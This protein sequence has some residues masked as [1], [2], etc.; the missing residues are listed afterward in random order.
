[1]KKSYYAVVGACM[2]FA[3]AGCR[4]GEESACR[5]P[6]PLVADGV[7]KCRV[8]VSEDA[9]S[10]EKFGAE[11]LAKYLDKA[12]GCGALNGAYPIRISVKSLPELE[13]DGFVLDVRADGMDIVGAN[14]RGALYGCYEVLKRYAGIR[15]LVPGD[16]GEYVPQAKT[17]TAPVGRLVRNPYLKIREARCD[18][19][20]PGRY[21]LVRNNMLSTGNKRIFFDKDGKL[22]K[23]GELFE[24]LTVRGTGASGH[25]MSTMLLGSNS[26]E[27][28]E[29]LF[30]VHPEYFPLID[31]K[32]KMI[33]T[34][35]DPNPCVSNPAVLDI[36]A[37]NLVKWLGGEHGS[38]TYCE[39][40]NNDTTLWCQ[41]DK[42]KALDPA[43][44]KGTR[45]E[46]SDRYW[47]FMNELGKRV[48]PKVP[49][50]KL[51]GAPY[52]NFWFAP[53][54]VKP[55]PR[56][57]CFISFNNQCWRHS[58]CDPKCSVN[59]TMCD[60]FNGFKKFGMPLVF[61]RDEI[62][63]WDGQ[64][65]PG[66]EFQPAEGVFAQNCL[67]YPEIAC[68]G[69]H[70]CVAGPCP[71][72]SDF[73]KNWSPFYGKRYH[74]YA[75][76][77]TCYVASLMMYDPKTDWKSELEYAN[78]LFYGAA[79]EGGM[80][81]F[82]ALLTKCF[83]EAPGCVGWGQHA[84]MGRC[85]DQAGSEEK[86]KALLEKAIAAAKASGD[87]RT[88]KHVLREKEIFE[89]TWLVQ[90]K[91]YL[92]NFKELSVYRRTGEIKLDGVL[93]EADWKNAD[94]V[95]DFQVKPGVRA[96]VQAY[97][98]VVYDKDTLYVAVEAMEPTPEKILSPVNGGDALHDL[99]DRIELFY[100]YPDMAD[101]AYHLCINSK[102][103]CV[104]A[105]QNS[106]SD[107]VVFQTAAKI[108][109]KVGKDRWT[110]E[111][112]IPCSEIGQNCFDGAS[113]K[114]NVA[115][116]RF[117]EGMARTYSSSCCKGWFHGPA[118]FLNIKFTPARIKGIGQ[119]HT[120]SSWN[121]PGFNAN[122]KLDK[123]DK[124]RFKGY[125]GEDDREPDGWNV[126][127]VTGEYHKK[128][129]VEGQGQEGGDDWYMTLRYAPNNNVRQ[130]FK[131]DDA[132]KLKAIFKARGKGRLRLWTCSFVLTPDKKDYNADGKTQK[133]FVY[134][135][136]DDWQTFTAVVEK[137]ALPTDRVAFWFCADKDSVVDLDDAVV[138]RIE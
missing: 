4:F 19:E 112:A 105:R 51:C 38:E 23:D 96:D 69:S 121:N 85:L 12:T 103:T 87:A 120:T 30:A 60:I 123:R 116:E 44:T 58:V 70:L 138:T 102:G 78:R 75:M 15:W 89:L 41:C 21:W 118:N 124:A 20:M 125:V 100:N 117:V 45:G 6:A 122:H 137:K 114:L 31:G 43:E 110:L 56:L 34:H 40:G 71:E 67:E 108:A 104:A 9:S 93:D 132:A 33:W 68:N 131:I 62:G 130:Y 115:R 35:N 94:S 59:K 2:L 50:A 22:T 16:D 82:R 80:K 48:W 24:K 36:M 5:G 92:E 27:A 81:E 32:R 74:W 65:S 99:G 73:A 134:D 88:L 42:C 29:K 10:P 54:K 98:R 57:Y 14:P 18:D 46:L 113:W 106:T 8:V 128:V 17:V 127:D 37:A 97:V 63:A 133:S 55:D 76:W 25:L 84:P 66:C 107:R 72:Y 91:K 83:L 101:R 47:W 136:T 119:N 90:R 1:M 39:I 64:G 109:T 52:Q 126:M 79:W 135:L 95:S 129:K 7:A 11:E 61:N 77:Q 49:Q 86:L 13:E 111:M 53:V 3:G 26:K 28:A